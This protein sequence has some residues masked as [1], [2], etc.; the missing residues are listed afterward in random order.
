MLNVWAIP[1]DEVLSANINIL[2]ELGKIT[3]MKSMENEMERLKTEKLTWQDPIHTIISI[4]LNI[5]ITPY[6]STET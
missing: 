2:E 3:T 6:G 5:F 4:F 1:A